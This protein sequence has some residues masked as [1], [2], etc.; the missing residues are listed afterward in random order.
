MRLELRLKKVSA[1]SGV[2]YETV[3]KDYAIGHV[4]AALAAEESLAGTLV[5]KGGTALRKLHFADYRFSEDLDFTALDAP[6]GDDLEAGLRSAAR[7]ARERMEASGPFAVTV[8]R[9]VLKE[10]HPGEQEAFVVRI[11]FPWQR[12]PLCVLKVEVT[13]DEPVLLPTKARPILQGYEEELPGRVVCYSLEEIV[14]EKLRALLQNEERRKRRA[15]IR[16]RCRDFYDLWTLLRK[17]QS[18]FNASAVRRH[19]PAKCEVR[20]VSFRTWEDFFPEPLVALVVDA[21]E[22]DLGG[23]VPEMPEAVMVV[24]EL[25]GLVAKLLEAEG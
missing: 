15:W 23:L 1:A 21:W 2:P 10:Q 12:E 7:R 13:A 20:G 11:Q 18:G 19:L 16:P 22:G 9:V 3:L 14:C 24:E 6:R 5:M 8:D 4:L 25:K 17:P